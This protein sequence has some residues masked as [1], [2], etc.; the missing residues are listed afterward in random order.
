MLLQLSQGHQI[1]GL[2]GGMLLR[3]QPAG[4]E[5]G[6]DAVLSHPKHQG[7]FSRPGRRWLPLS[8]SLEF[9]NLLL[10]PGLEPPPLLCLD[11][12]RTASFAPSDNPFLLWM[13]T[14]AGALGGNRTRE[15][16]VWQKSQLTSG[17]AP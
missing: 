4:F 10:L 9:F 2:T 15:K 11:S 13:E 5:P 3:L 1:W 14:S 17:R 16:R 8:L 7:A 12:P 6:P